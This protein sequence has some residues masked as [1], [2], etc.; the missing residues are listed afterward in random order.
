MQGYIKEIENVI[1]V[2]ECTQIIKSS[3]NRG[4]SKATIN[5]TMNTD[6]RKSSR[7]VID[8]EDFSRIFYERLKHHIP[9]TFKG[10]NFAYINPFF[11]VLKYNIGDEFKPHTDGQFVDKN[12]NVSKLTLLLYLNEDYKGGYTSILTDNKWMSIVPK[13]GKVLLQ[14][15]SILH[16]VF[17]IE[18][19][20]KY[21]IRTD[22]MYKV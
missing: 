12:N 22:L 8:D 21:V 15:Q 16:A 4:F 9:H 6:I 17:P 10:F 18:E 20:I 1:S 13:Q 2:E 3:E 19:G 7:V 5:N 11:R 14:E